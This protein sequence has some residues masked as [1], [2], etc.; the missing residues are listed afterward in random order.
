M[1]SAKSA[2]QALLEAAQAIGARN[3]RVVTLPQLLADPEVARV[4]AIP[5][6]AIGVMRELEFHGYVRMT[7]G[8]STTGPDG[9]AAWYVNQLAVKTEE[10]L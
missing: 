3:R 8:G 7:T 4:V 1:S 9:N 6:R 2:T 10:A 5:A